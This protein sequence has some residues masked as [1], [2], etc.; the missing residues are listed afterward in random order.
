MKIIYCPLIKDWI[1]LKDCGECEMCDADQAIN[2][3]ELELVISQY[4]K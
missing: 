4:H 2:E 3:K 1:K